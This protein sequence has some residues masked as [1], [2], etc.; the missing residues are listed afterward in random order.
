MSIELDTGVSKRSDQDRRRRSTAPKKLPASKTASQTRSGTSEHRFFGQLDNVGGNLAPRQ[1]IEH[2]NRAIEAQPRDHQ[3]TQHRPS[4]RFEPNNPVRCTCD[5]DNSSCHRFL[6]LRT[7][8]NR[9]LADLEPAR[10]QRL[11]SAIETHVI[12]DSD[13]GIDHCLDRRPIGARPS[14]HELDVP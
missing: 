9:T 4:D 1:P 3:T 8:N 14:P 12:G 13:D 10:G 5:L 6:I 2:L 11:E 7:T